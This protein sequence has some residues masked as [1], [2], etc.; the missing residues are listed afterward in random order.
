[1]NVGGVGF[2]IPRARFCGLFDLAYVT[3]DQLQ[4]LSRIHRL[5][6]DQKEYFFCIHTPGNPVE[7]GILDRQRK[8][9]MTTAMAFEVSTGQVEEDEYKRRR[10]AVMRERT[11][12]RR[13]EHADRESEA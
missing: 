10:K 11:A 4:A 7:R 1:M 13:K 6:Q 9:I 5:G 12:R 3:R 2:N 8:R